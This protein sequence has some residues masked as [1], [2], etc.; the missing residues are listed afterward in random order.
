MNKHYATYRI[1]QGP[2]A[3]PMIS[4]CMHECMHDVERVL[5]GLP[6]SLISST[7]SVT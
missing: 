2:F 5:S 7:E 6:K 4:R 3:F 1:E